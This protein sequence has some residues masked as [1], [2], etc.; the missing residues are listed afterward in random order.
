[1]SDKFQKPS[2]ESDPS[3]PSPANTPVQ[4]EAKPV[5]GRYEDFEDASDLDEKARDDEYFQLKDRKGEAGLAWEEDEP[6]DDDEEYS[7]ADLLDTDDE[8]DLEDE[9]EDDLEDEEDE[10]EDDEFEDDEFEDDESEDD[11]YDDDKD[12]EEEEEVE[13]GQFSQD[14]LYNSLTS[15]PLFAQVQQLLTG[16][17]T[18]PEKTFTQAR[19]LQATNDLEGAAQLY[20]DVIE[21][22]P[23]HFK[24]HVALGQVLMA[25]DKPQEAE[26]FLRKAVILDPEDPS[27]FLYLGY[28][29]Y[30]QEQFEECVKD[31]AKAVELDKSNPLALNNL[32]FVQYLTG[33][34]DDAAA[35]FTLAGDFGSDRAYYNLGLVRLLQGRES[36]GWS[37]YLEAFDLDPN[38]R[39][40]EDHL[41]DVQKA[42]LAHPDKA[43]VLDDA[44]TRL[45]S[46]Y[47]D[48][49]EGYDDD[50]S[51]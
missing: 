41:V 31:F 29:H 14:Q 22:A 16:S 20:L 12:E 51:D 40:I 17:M 26:T 48:A 45:Y 21:E 9:D 7:E 39:Q 46:R 33:Q 32:G 38:G 10:F 35:T 27:G 36:E 8:D 13:P 11:A 42:L 1:M 37:A 47:G 5:L 28:A 23:E 44:I 3:Q 15:N 6:D 19:M 2:P 34:L 4:P 24:A 30:A 49:G 50:D 25:M 43:P 18:G